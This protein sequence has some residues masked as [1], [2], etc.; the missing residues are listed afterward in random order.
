MKLLDA[1]LEGNPLDDLG[2]PIGIIQLSPFALRRHHQPAP[3]GAP[4]F[5]TEAAPGFASSVTDGGEDTLY[6]VRSSDER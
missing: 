5:A 1:V 6:G 2:Q 4:G 3:H